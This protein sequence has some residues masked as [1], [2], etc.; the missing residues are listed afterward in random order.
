MLRTPFVIYNLHTTD[1]GV[2]SP[3]PPPPFRGG[4]PFADAKYG[5]ILLK[6]FNKEFLL[7]VGIA[8]DSAVTFYVKK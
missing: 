6:I 5:F 1:G 8:P 2:Q 3:P 4:G 7:N